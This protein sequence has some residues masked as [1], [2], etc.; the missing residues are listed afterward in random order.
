MGSNAIG[1]GKLL[2]GRPGVEE[3]L[4]VFEG[5]WAQEGVALCGVTSGAEGP[6]ESDHG[7]PRRR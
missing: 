4:H 7:P 6:N 3:G 1:P 5:E 2:L